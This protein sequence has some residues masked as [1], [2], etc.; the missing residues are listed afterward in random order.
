MPVFAETNACVYLYLL[1]FSLTVSTGN[2][3]VE[4]IFMSSIFAYLSPDAGLPSSR[5]PCKSIYCTVLVV[6]PGSLCCMCPY[7][8]SR[9]LE[10][11]LQLALLSFSFES[12]NSLYCVQTNTPDRIEFMGS[13]EALS[14]RSPL[15]DVRLFPHGPAF[16]TI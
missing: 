4:H 2:T 12:P 3:I 5:F 6:S 15:V 8:P 16:S 10:T 13:I 14:F 9:R 11:E 7:R 1:T